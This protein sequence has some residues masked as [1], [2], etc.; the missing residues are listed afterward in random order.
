MCKMHTMLRATRRLRG[1][2]RKEEERKGGGKKKGG[3]SFSDFQGLGSIPCPS[4]CADAGLQVARAQEEKKGRRRGEREGGRK[5]R[6][7]KKTAPEG[8]EQRPP[9][10]WRVG[11]SARGV[12]KKYQLGLGLGNLGCIVTL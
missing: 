7:R 8:G 9:E 12:A 11:A 2:M 3:G 5:K 10:H 1:E 6:R 4:V